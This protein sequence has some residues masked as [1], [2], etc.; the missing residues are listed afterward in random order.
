MYIG[1]FYEDL[2]GITTNFY[3]TN[4]LKK[5]PS[6]KFIG[7]PSSTLRLLINKVRLLKENTYTEIRVFDGEYVFILYKRNDELSVYYQWKYRII[8]INENFIKHE[9]RLTK[10][11]LFYKGNYLDFVKKVYEISIEFKNKFEKYG[12]RSDAEAELYQQ[13]PVLEK[14]IKKLEKPNI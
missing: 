7:L 13:I 3:F 8:K 5:I 14:Y 9:N 4:S 6:G 12:I 2:P 10:K 11:K 1:E